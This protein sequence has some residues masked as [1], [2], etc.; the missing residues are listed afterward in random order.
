MSMGLLV[1]GWVKERW[2]AWRKLRSRVE[3]GV[4]V[5]PGMMWGAP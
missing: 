5:A 3:F 1:W 4:G 2:A